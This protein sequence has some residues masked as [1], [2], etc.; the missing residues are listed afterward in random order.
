MNRPIVPLLCALALFGLAG[1]AVAQDGGLSAC[2]GDAIQLAAFDVACPSAFA[3]AP[4][5]AEA[6]VSWLTG[7]AVGKRLSPVRVSAVDVGIRSEIVD[8][9]PLFFADC[10]WQD[11]QPYP[12]FSGRTSLAEL[13][14]EKLSG[15]DQ[16]RIGV[17]ADGVSR[18][19]IKLTAP[20]DGAFDAQI[21]GS[22]DNG[23][24]AV[25]NSGSTCGVDG[26][27]LA[28][29]VY[30]AP[31]DFGLG[32]GLR[33]PE[34]KVGPAESREVFVKVVFTPTDTERVPV[35]EDIVDLQVVRPPVVLVHGLFDN[36]VDCWM[37]PPP[38]GLDP[39]STAV[40]TLPARLEVSG[41][42]PFLVDYRVTNGSRDGNANSSFED[43]AFVVWTNGREPSWM[44]STER[45]TPAT[46]LTNPTTGETARGGGI[47]HALEYYRNE[48][49]IAVAQADVVG[50]SMGG[51]L[52]RVN[53]AKPSYRRVD[54]FCAGDINRLV[55]IGTPHHGSELMEVFFHLT[56]S[57]I[58]DEAWSSFLLRSTASFASDLYFGA[59][60]GSEAM[61]DLDVGS[62]ALRTIGTTRI[63]SHV[64]VG[65]TREGGLE[66]RLYDE[67]AR[68]LTVFT[69]AG[70]MFWAYPEN[71][72]SYLDEISKDWTGPRAEA[73]ANARAELSELIES[74]Y[75]YWLALR[76]SGQMES[77]L[78]PGTARGNRVSVP[79]DVPYLF[80]DALRNL[81]FRFDKNDSIVRVASQLGGLDPASQY[82]TLVDIDPRGA[83][84]PDIAESTLHSWE[85]QHSKLQIHLARLLKSGLERFADELPPA[86]ASLEGAEP[87]ANLGA[88]WRVTGDCAAAWSNMAPRHVDAFREVAQQRN[89]IVMV[90]PVNPDATPLIVR[91]EAT[92]GMNVKGKSSSWGPQ[93]GYIP[94]DQTY[95]KLWRTLKDNPAKR[96]SEIRKY[97]GK[98]DEVLYC[99]AKPGESDDDTRKR[100]GKYTIPA[101]HPVNPGQPIAVTRPLENAWPPCPHSQDAA[102]VA[103]EG[104]FCGAAPDDACRASQRVYSVWAKPRVA[105][106]GEE[107]ESWLFFC[108]ERADGPR[109]VDACTCEQFFDWRTAAGEF[110]LEV[111]PSAAVTPQSCS[112][113][114]PLEVLADNSHPQTAY[115]TADYDLLAIGFFCP[116]GGPRSPGCQSVGPGEP[117][118]PP[119]PFDPFKGCITDEQWNLVDA[120]NEAVEHS[121]HTGGRVVHHG[122]ENNFNESPYVDYPITVFEPDPDAGPG[123]K[124][125]VLSIPK[126]PK[127]F[128]DLHLKR[129]FERKIRQGY[130]LYPNTHT[131]AMWAW[132]LK[133]PEGRWLGWNEEDQPAIWGAEDPDQLT[134]PPCALDL[135]DD[136]SSGAERTSRE[137]SGG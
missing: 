90:R 123:G 43:N 25:V 106:T 69:W 108:R 55:T 51:L 11:N 93:K 111:E 7:E 114:R 124:A 24:L 60:G 47:R 98:T 129:Y 31:A 84:T 64:V 121:G 8:A 6:P 12:T 113:L 87:P 72:E 85:P 117:P 78:N 136:S 71:L 19:L 37:T 107:A 58:E 53:A 56:Q 75:G 116:E 23:E 130:W 80:L 127:G 73:F 82:V 21:L 99:R 48:L 42:V 67:S 112:E 17:A 105:E 91:G 63:P 61:R 14:F 104:Q 137:S 83:T 1:I 88:A 10:T 102:C 89:T 65:V 15:L 81:I 94:A 46:T 77:W 16:G 9:N 34:E 57:E 44:D 54:N 134:P 86:G 2:R 4:D 49:G 110:D 35:L 92:K 41:I 118:S 97:Q 32:S 122:P 22:G 135:V 45:Y 33:P 39:T 40:E 18:L 36:P 74:E 133:N 125:R 5:E 30:R 120:L 119:P 96:R 101:D 76:E 50:H 128:R 27:H 52:A 79:V 26:G 20:A 100:C 70:A 28:F 59:K 103:E 13:S 132:A 109:V 38:Y 68:Y 29:L 131:T 126:G 66:D 3:E 95:S 115:L 62:D